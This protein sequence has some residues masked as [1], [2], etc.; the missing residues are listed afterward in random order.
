MAEITGFLDVVRRDEYR[1]AA[2]T[3]Q[4]RN[5]IPYEMGAR[6]IEAT[7]RLIEKQ[8]LRIAHQRGA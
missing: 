7:G 2:F 8:D 6:D 3:V 5:D 4:A 1:H